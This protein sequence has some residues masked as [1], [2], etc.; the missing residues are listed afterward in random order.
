MVRVPQGIT[1]KEFRDWAKE[2]MYPFDDL[3]TMTGSNGFAVPETLFVDMMVVGDGVA[4]LPFYVSA[5]NATSATGVFDVVVSDA[6]GIEIG[7]A[8]IYPSLYDYASLLDANGVN[9]GS[10]VV[11]DDEAVKMALALSGKNESF[12]TALPILASRCYTAHRPWVTRLGIAGATVSG[13]VIIIGVA[14][15]KFELK[16]SAIVL[17]YE[18]TDED[19]SAESV[20]TAGGFIKSVNGLQLQRPSFV[21]AQT[22]SVKVMVNGPK[23]ALQAIENVK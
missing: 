13:D 12:G 17:S 11:D 23:L 8:P 19:G 20:S 2:A 21:A 1:G 14:G 15:V 6:R 5:L 16:D 7:R 18:G 22:S 4:R 3:A 9:V 10:V